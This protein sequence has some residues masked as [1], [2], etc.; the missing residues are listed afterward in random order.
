MRLTVNGETYDHRGPETVSALLAA[1]GAIPERVAVT[2]NG[3]VIPRGERDSHCLG[4]NDRIEVL[5]FCGGG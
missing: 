3:E 1:L 4:E 5:T 2:V